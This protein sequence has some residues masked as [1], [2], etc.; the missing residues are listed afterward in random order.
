MIILI[1]ILSVLALLA[2][3]TREQVVRIILML[4]I[5][6]LTTIPDYLIKTVWRY[7]LVIDSSSSSCG[8]CGYGG[9]M[10]LHHLPEDHTRC[11]GCGG[12]WLFGWMTYYIPG[13]TPTEQDEE[14]RDAT[15][16]VAEHLGV[17]L[18]GNA[19]GDLTYREPRIHRL[20]DQKIVN[21]ALTR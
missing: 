18:L 12:R 9:Y 3:L 21:Q 17:R 15:L 19:S 10:I 20:Y 4:A 6:N 14:D 7:S 13:L 11:A 16:R 2:Y 5:P 1:G 8:R